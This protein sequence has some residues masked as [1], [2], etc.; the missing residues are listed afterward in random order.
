[1]DKFKQSSRYPSAK[2]ATF[3]TACLQSARNIRAALPDQLTPLHS[4]PIIHTVHSNVGSEDHVI[5]V[6]RDKRL[7]RKGHTN[8]VKWEPFQLRQSRC[9]WDF[10]L[11]PK[12][13][14]STTPY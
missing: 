3:Q 8:V 12:T 7:G 14:L 1:M 6:D 11:L 4:P 10:F 5:P 13:V 9:P 2:H